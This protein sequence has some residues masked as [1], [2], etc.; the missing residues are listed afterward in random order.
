MTTRHAT[1][2]V[3]VALAL[4]A[5]RDPAPSNTDLSQAAPPDMTAAADLSTSAGT[6]KLTGTVSYAGTKTGTLKFALYEMPPGPMTPPSQFMFAP[7]MNPT[8]PQAYALDAVKPGSFHVVVILDVDPPN[9]A[10]P[11]PEDVIGFSMTKVTVSAGATATMNVTLP[12][13]GDM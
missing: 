7:I 4:S 11:G 2:P 5:C 12:A 13:G 9:A 6:G 8:F 1:V 3:I 10:I